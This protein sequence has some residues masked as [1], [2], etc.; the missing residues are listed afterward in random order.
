MEDVAKTIFPELKPN[1]IVIGLG[2]GTIT[3]LGSELLKLND[4]VNV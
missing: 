1:D 2:A 3:K 4:G